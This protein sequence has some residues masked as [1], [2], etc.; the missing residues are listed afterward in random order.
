[1]SLSMA[2][3]PLFSRKTHPDMTEKLLTEDLK[4]QNKSDSQ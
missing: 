1:M 3:N 2:L 4:N